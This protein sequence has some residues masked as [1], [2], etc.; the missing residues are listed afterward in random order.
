MAKTKTGTRRRAQGRSIV[1]TTV[2]IFADQRDALHQAAAERRA[3]G[4]SAR[5]DASA[6]LRDLLDRQGLKG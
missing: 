3:R 4:E 6:V 2:R 1:V 5:V